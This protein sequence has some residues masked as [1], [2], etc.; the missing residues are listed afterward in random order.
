MN[1]GEY[2]KSELA[3]N[4]NVESLDDGIIIDG[5]GERKTN[6]LNVARDSSITDRLFSSRRQRDPSGKRTVT[7]KTSNKRMK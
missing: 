1:G 5:P 7:P 3:G 6:L 4:D 2:S